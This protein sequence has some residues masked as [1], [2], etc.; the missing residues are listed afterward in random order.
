MSSS[1]NN[2]ERLTRRIARLQGQLNEL[3]ER[4]KVGV[5]NYQDGWL[6]GYLDGNLA[7]LEDLLFDMQQDGQ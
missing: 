6:V 5:P 2:K 7:I 1:L 3:K 4:N